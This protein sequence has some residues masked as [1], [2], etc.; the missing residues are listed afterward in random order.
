MDKEHPAYIQVGAYNTGASAKI[1]ISKEFSVGEMHVGDAK[2]V[3]LTSDSNIVFYQFTA[4]EDGV[5]IF[6]TDS[7]NMVYVYACDDVEDYLNPDNMWGNRSSAMELKK[8][9]VKYIRV[10]EYK[11]NLSSSDAFTLTCKKAKETS[12]TGADALNLSLKKGEPVLVRWTA[13]V[14]GNYQFAFHVTNGGSVNYKYYKSKSIGVNPDDYY[15]T[16]SGNSWSQYEDSSLNGRN[17]ILEASERTQVEVSAQ[18][19][20]RS[21]SVYKT[22]TVELDSSKPYEE[23][24]FYMA[25]NTTYI[26]GTIDVNSALNSYIIDPD[27]DEWDDGTTYHVGNNYYWI[28]N[29]SDEYGKTYKFRVETCDHSSDSF[30]VSVYY[31]NNCKD[32]ELDSTG[33]ET[34]TYNV[35]YNGENWYRFRINETDWYGFGSDYNVYMSLYKLNGNRLELLGAKSDSSNKIWVALE[36]GDTV[37]AQTYYRSYHD[38]GSY[39]INV[40]CD[41]PQ[42]TSN[43]RISGSS[44]GSQS[45]YPSGRYETVMPLTFS[46]LNNN[47]K[48]AFAL[49]SDYDS[50][51]IEMAMYQIIGDSDSGSESKVLV[52]EG[53]SFSYEI[54]PNCSYE[55]RVS[56]YNSESCTVTAQK[57]YPYEAFELSLDNNAQ[58]VTVKDGSEARFS[59]TVPE[60]GSYLFY[61]TADSY[62]DNYAE[63]WVNDEYITYSDDDGGNGQF[64]I[65]RRLDAGD[66]VELRTYKLNHGSDQGTYT[67]HI[68]KVPE[69]YND[70]P[71][72]SS[73][74]SDASLSTSVDN[75]AAGETK[76]YRFIAPSTNND[77]TGGGIYSIAR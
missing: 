59:F 25:G 34:D 11:G 14:K 17:L 75:L 24:D 50:E 37:L 32:S 58:K 30:A 57:E 5:Y 56:N 45:R 46:G 41:L 69:D 3:T 7:E 2:D 19:V 74:T 40:T 60:N 42:T 36:Q 51:N 20:P 10:G 31:Y 55:L 28:F 47:T 62:Y 1:V 65:N 9:E 4:E 23:F 71:Q 26:F 6:N 18:I 12:F 29:T 8:G 35:R 54:D 48:Y 22:E 76:Q 64:S 33:L 72:M 66:I 44:S 73:N 70:L 15:S 63:L 13:G 68:E 43:W 52:A 77:N 61:G 38:S 16:S 27:T 67:V 39:S 49:T 21:I 53:H